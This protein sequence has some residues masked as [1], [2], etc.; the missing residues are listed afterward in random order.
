MEP[1]GDAPPDKIDELCSHECFSMRFKA[2]LKQVAPE[3][4]SST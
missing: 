4:E 2:A 3:P 1:Q